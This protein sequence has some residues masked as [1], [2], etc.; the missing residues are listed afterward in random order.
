VRTTR[1]TERVGRV[2]VP[3]GEAAVVAAS[4]L[5]W[6]DRGAGSTLALHDLGDLL[7]GG[8][9]SSVVPR[10][11][12]AIAYVIPACAAFAVLAAGIEGAAARRAVVA[13]VSGQAVLVVVATVLPLVRN[14]RPGLGQLLATVGTMAAVAGLLM[15]R[16][17]ARSVPSS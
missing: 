16:S 12:G 11:I 5:P 10:W 13:L 1:S 9:V 3:S 14:A 4:F 7:L 15:R 2:L 8:A 6:V 17:G